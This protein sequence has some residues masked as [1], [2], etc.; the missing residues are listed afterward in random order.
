MKFL[1]WNYRGL[2]NLSTVRELKHLL[3]IKDPGLLLLCETKLNSRKFKNVRSICK[4]EG[5]FVIDS[6]GHKGG[7]VLLWKICS[8]V[9]IQHHSQNHNDSYIELTN[10]NRMRFTGFYGFNEINKTS[11]SW[12]DP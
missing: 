3:A 4:M 6:V 9:R 11:E 1:S 12:G 10:G 8:D 2:G 7:L 5:C